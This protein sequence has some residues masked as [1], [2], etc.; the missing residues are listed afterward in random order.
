MGF[1]SYCHVVPPT[2]LKKIRF[3]SPCKKKSRNLAF[4]SE[5]TERTIFFFIIEK[6]SSVQWFH[7][8]KRGFVI[9]LS[10]ATKTEFFEIGR[11]NY[12]ELA[13]KP[14]IPFLWGIFLRLGS[15]SSC[16]DALC[17]RSESNAL[18]LQ[19]REVWLLSFRHGFLFVTFFRGFFYQG[20]Y[21]K[22]I[23]FPVIRTLERC[24]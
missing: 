20:S 1:G 3:R 19:N 4:E 24:R 23:I 14:H 6:K 8:W 9:F 12:I 5:F 2:N 16:C 10:G 18:S 21:P 15:T 17:M 22:P 13:S 7:F 11:W